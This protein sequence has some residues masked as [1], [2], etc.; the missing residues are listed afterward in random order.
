MA[1]TDYKYLEII[2]KA[3][4]G[5]GKKFSQNA[6]S[7]TPTHKPSSILGCWVINHKFRPHYQKDMVVVE[8]C[9]DINVWYSY[10]NNSKTEVASETVNYRDEIP[11]AIKDKKV[12][13]DRLEVFAHAIQEPNSLE[14]NISPNGNKI[15]VQVEKELHVE[16][17]GE[18]KVK[19]NVDADDAIDGD[20]WEDALD[21]E[22]GDL[23]SEFL[24]GDLDE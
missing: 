2:T 19:V 23:D 20:D 9:Y 11:L 21:E 6:H 3:I 5:K 10:N 22:F 12:V 17:I 14:T 18:T 13:S 15:V 4:C 24:V 1:E 7:I 16:L 8:G